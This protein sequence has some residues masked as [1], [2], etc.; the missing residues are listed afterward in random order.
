MEE[1]ICFKNLLDAAEKAKAI[2]KVRPSTKESEEFYGFRQDL[3]E[4]EEII[5]NALLG[6]IRDISMDIDSRYE[7]MHQALENIISDC[8]DD[9]YDDDALDKVS[10]WADADTDTYTSD[11][12]KWLSRSVDNVLYL[13]EALEEGVDIDDGF[14]LLQIAQCKAR[15]EVYTA[16]IRALE[17]L[18]DENPC[19]D[20]DEDDSDEDDTT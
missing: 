1:G 17:E 19:E 11:L 15:D 6:T 2:M 20:E 3:S 8:D 7:F 5:H 12:T 16:T 9:S 10:E 4:S 18:V 13:D 14:K